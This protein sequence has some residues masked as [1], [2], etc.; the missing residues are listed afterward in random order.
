MKTSLP[1]MYKSYWTVEELEMARAL[2][3]DLKLDVCKP[4]YYAEKLISEAL[5]GTEYGFIRILEAEAEINN[6]GL[7]YQGEYATEY[8]CMNCL[9]HATARIH[10]GKTHDTAF[11]EIYGWITDAF[12]AGS[13]NVK[14]KIKTFI[15]TK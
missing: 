15:Y 9:I 4:D 11:M 5:R 10:S 8:S 13:E 7:P 6:A 1:T 14:D 2:Q 3:K 12:K